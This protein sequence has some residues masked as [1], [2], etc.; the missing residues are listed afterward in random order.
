[1]M[2]IAVVVM[3]TRLTPMVKFVIMLVTIIVHSSFYKVDRLR[4]LIKLDGW[5]AH[6][7]RPCIGWRR[8]SFKRGFRSI[9]VLQQRI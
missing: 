9:G 4:T 7:L 3:V 2:V 1:M 6:T 8:L 5:L